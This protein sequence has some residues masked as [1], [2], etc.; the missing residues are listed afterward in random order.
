M[1]IAT[2]HDL[3]V[4]AEKAIS[5]KNIYPYISTSKWLKPWVI[6]TERWNNLFFTNTSLGYLVSIQFDRIRDEISIGLWADD[7]QQASIAIRGIREYIRRTKPRAI[8]SVVHASNSKSLR[9]H[10]K[11]FGA[12]WG[13]ENKYAWN[14]LTGEYED[15]YYFR[16]IL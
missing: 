8:N 11:I 15:F 14:S 7:S 5:N 4:F 10:K 6:D 9:L 16:L 3:D 1:K 2:Q 13:I 12:S